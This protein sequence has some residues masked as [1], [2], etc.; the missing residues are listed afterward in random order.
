MDKID[1]STIPK[2]HVGGFAIHYSPFAKYL[3]YTI[4][5]TF[6]SN[7]HV[8]YL[9]KIKRCKRNIPPDAKLRIINGVV[10]P[11]FDYGS[12]LYH[13]HKISGTNADE[14]RIQVAHNNCI[15]CINNF[16]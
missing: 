7:N 3:G 6:N 15:R 10:L 4:N 14:K 11:L 13:G 12:V 8:E 5:N 16:E 9:S 1:H 2:I